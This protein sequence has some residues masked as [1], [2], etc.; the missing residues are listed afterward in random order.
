MNNQNTSRRFILSLLLIVVSF[1][2]LFLIAYKSLRFQQQMLNQQNRDEKFRQL[3]QLGQTF[4]YQLENSSMPAEAIPLPLARSAF[5]RLA[6]P[7]SPNARNI[8][9]KMT[10]KSAPKT[11]L[12][13]EAEL[14]ASADEQ[15]F[16]RYLLLQQYS[17]S[18]NFFE[19]RRCAFQILNSNFDYL[20]ENGRTLKTETAIKVAEAF[21][22]ENNPE[23][24]RQWL[25]RLR[26]LPL[27]LVIPETPQQLVQG[28][29]PDNLKSWLQLLLFCYQLSY[30][31]K[32]EPGWKSGSNVETLLVKTA[33]GFAAFSSATIIAGLTEL[34]SQR[35][36]SETVVTRYQPDSGYSHLLTAPQGLWVNFKAVETPVPFPGG[37]I[38]LIVLTSAGILGLFWFS[39][40]EWQFIQKAR[41][42]EEEEN[43]FRQTAHD[44]K[45]P[46]TNVSFL[47]ETL[48]LKRYKS[49]EQQNRYLSQ[50]HTE[51]SKA[52]ELFDRLLL[53]VRLRR[54][55]VKAEVRSISPV[56][57]LKSLVVRFKS[58]M[59]NWEILEQF[60]TC[61]PV[62]ADPDMF[63]RVMI[64]LIEN[65]LRHAASGQKLFLR[66]S[67]SPDGNPAEI[68]VMI[69]DSGNAFPISFNNGE[70]NLLNDSLLY[71][72]ERGGSGTGLFLV[73][74]IINTHKG[75]FSARAR[76]DH[77]VWMI[78]TWKAAEK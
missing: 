33:E 56:D 8:F 18:R 19:M 20:L 35:G 51:T 69:G 78:T 65:V 46:I 47:A 57:T 4:F 11:A 44:L 77:G 75:K 1:V 30:A 58:R 70:I 24:C 76:E 22:Q 52:A 48:A 2:L 60:E 15:D 36:F 26:T 21:L 63:E 40:H 41:L 61:A 37:F 53:S 7:D 10:M 64:N 27:P 32:I 68:A 28:N 49:D 38:L 59:Q 62:A 14:N 31:E 66:T 39:L 50:L 29:L 42:L 71:R 45:T 55:A 43:F 34:F 13:L 16:W 67:A 9:L 72:P 6:A 23:S 5:P 3:D 74:Q 73:R 17:S 54:N 12:L 25:F